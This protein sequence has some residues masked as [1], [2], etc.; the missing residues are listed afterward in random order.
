MQV[1]ATPANHR[2]RDAFETQ[3]EVTP[4]VPLP[5]TEG[6]IPQSSAGRPVP[7]SQAKDAVG[8]TPLRPLA[9]TRLLIDEPV[10][11]PSS[12]LMGRKVR[13]Q[14]AF[15]LAVS[16]VS[17]TPVKQGLAAPSEAGNV[18]LATPIKKSSQAMSKAFVD[19]SPTGKENKASIYDRLGWDDDLYDL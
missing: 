3:I 1:E 16:E 9:S 11:S 18:L 8:C 5:S 7:S 19:A 17:S 13:S 15:A 4:D 10:M 14:G 2:F 12:P 6:I